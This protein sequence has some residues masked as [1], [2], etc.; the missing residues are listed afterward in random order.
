M[1]IRV[2][3][4]REKT[5]QLLD[6]AGKAWGRAK[7]TAILLNRTPRIY[8]TERVS[9]RPIP[10]C[11]VRALRAGG[12]LYLRLHWD[13][14]TKNAPQAPPRR[15]G[16]AGHLPRRPTAHTS[17]FPDAAAVMV[18]VHWTGPAFPSLLMGDKNNP[19]LLYYWNASRGG[20]VLKAAGRATPQPTGQRF[21]HRARHDGKRWAVALALPAPP[22]GSPLAFAVWDGGAGDRDGLKFFSP[23]Y[24][25]IAR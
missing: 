6:P 3:R 21:P 9:S 20:E 22:V 12:R 17:A 25:L 23:W 8:Q 1:R 4:A 7:P 5:Q 24:V 11:E 18:P 15:R 2:F 19:V 14:P 16:G 10:G 13:D